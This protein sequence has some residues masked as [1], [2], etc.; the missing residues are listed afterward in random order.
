MKV[1]AEAE[2]RLVLYQPWIGAFL[3]TSLRVCVC[4][5]HPRLLPLS[6][7]DIPLPVTTAWRS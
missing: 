7:P 6:P 3:H 2:N 4:Q 1:R 5:T